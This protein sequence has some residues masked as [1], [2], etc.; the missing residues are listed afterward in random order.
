MR[1]ALLLILLLLT[2]NAGLTA[3]N[4]IV[5]VEGLVTAVPNTV[6]SRT[7][8]LTQVHSADDLPAHLRITLPSHVEVKVGAKIN[9]SGK[10]RTSSG[11]KYIEVLASKDIH[12]SE[13]EQEIIP[14][15][16]TNIDTATDVFALTTTKGMV[17]RR[18][19]RGFVLTTDTNQEV[20]VVLPASVKKPDRAGMNVEVTGIYSPN[21]SGDRILIRTEEDLIIEKPP[22]STPPKAQVTETQNSAQPPS[23][24]V[25]AT[26]IALTVLGGGAWWWFRRPKKLTPEEL[27]YE[28]VDEEDD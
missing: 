6:A 19:S 8:Y 23:L 12:V 16:L 17:A 9:L 5:S 14:I 4:P 13:G 18:T 20:G 24:F 15:T 27:P 3:K 26:S 7:L 2:P 21:Q 11:Q 22:P 25:G 10:L 1:T 28:L